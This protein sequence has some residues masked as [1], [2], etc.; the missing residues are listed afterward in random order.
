MLSY[1]LCKKW[2][3]FVDI[4]R[5]ANDASGG[6]FMAFMGWLGEQPAGDSPVR[7]NGKYYTVSNNGELIELSGT[8]SINYDLS[9]GNDTI[10][11]W[12][13]VLDGWTLR[14]NKD[15]KTISGT[16]PTGY[17]FEYPFEIILGLYKLLDQL[18]EAH[19]ELRTNQLGQRVKTKWDDQQN[20]P[21]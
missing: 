1:E 11:Q 21:I 13:E 14:F 18:L 7:F 19:P 9:D 6:S 16:H 5:D 17:S 8:G 15:S 10:N 4:P 2:K 20:E 3:E 12:P